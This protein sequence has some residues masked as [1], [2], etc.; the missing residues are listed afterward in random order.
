MNVLKPAFKDGFFDVVISNWISDDA[1]DRRAALARLCRLVKP[2][3]HV[4]LGVHSRYSRR[5]RQ[6][7]HVS[8]SRASTTSYSIDEVLDWMGEDGVEFINSIPRLSVGSTEASDER[9]FDSREA[10]S[11]VSRFLSQ[12]A[13]RGSAGREC[14]DFLLVGRR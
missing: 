11:A 10:G 3:G 2:G 8:F 6:A 13:D 7:N 4:V 1:G 12:A 9:L 14:G 5:G